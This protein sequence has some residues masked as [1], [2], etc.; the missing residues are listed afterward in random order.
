MSLVEQREEIRCPSTEAGFEHTQQAP[1]HNKLTKVVDCSATHGSSTPAVF[2]QC[3]NLCCMTLIRLQG[4]LTK[5]TKLP[6]NNAREI[7]STEGLSTQRQYSTDRSCSE[8]RTSLSHR[9]ANSLGVQQ[10]LRCRCCLR[11]EI[12]HV[13]T[14][15]ETWYTHRGP[16]MTKCT[17]RKGAAID[18]G[19]TFGN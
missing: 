12:S 2:R 15:I 17:R 7:V 11:K 1:T 13:R 19:Q 3:F 10:F 5:C 8:P 14:F 9:G 4:L 6:H 18:A 16:S